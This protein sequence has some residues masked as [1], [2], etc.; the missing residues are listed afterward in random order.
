M[1]LCREKVCVVITIFGVGAIKDSLSDGL[2]MACEATFSP[3]CAAADAYGGA[4]N[5]FVVLRSG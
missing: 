3:C 2:S 5:V 1:G 4:A